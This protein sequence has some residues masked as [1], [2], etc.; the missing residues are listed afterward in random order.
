MSKSR[1]IKKSVLSPTVLIAGGAGF[2]GSHLAETLLEQKVNVVIVDNIDISGKE[3]HIENLL[4]NENFAF[5]DADINKGLPQEIESVDYVF[6]LTGVETYM[7]S[8]G[9]GLETLLANSLGTKNLLDFAQNCGA[10][11][12]LVSSTD[13]Y[14][15]LL[16]SQNLIHYFGKTEFEERRYSLIEAKRYAEALVWE[17]FKKYDL[18]ARIV[19]IPKVFGPRMPLNSTD[20]L[21]SAIKDLLE[22]HNLRLHG[23]GTEKN[24]YLYI[25]D[26]V[27]GILKAVFSGE[28]KGNIYSLVTKEPFTALEVIYLLKSMANRELNVEFKPKSG[29]I[30]QRFVE[31]DTTNLKELE[32][33][34]KIDFKSGMA[35]TLKWF[36]Y[37]TNEHSF[38]AN[39]LI[40]EN[41]KNKNKANTIIPITAIA[42]A[43]AEAPQPVEKQQHGFF[44]KKDK[45]VEMQTRD[46]PKVV[47]Q[48]QLKEVQPTKP[49]SPKATTLKK[50][51]G[52]VYK[53]FST[54]LKVLTPILFIAIALVGVPMAQTYFYATKARTSLITVEQD[55]KK[56]DFDSAQAHSNAAYLDFQKAQNSLKMS[57]WLFKISG[58]QD[59]YEAL[60]NTLNS[61]ENFSKAIY[62]GTKAASPFS[63]IWS[64]LR[65]DLENR[66]TA[67]QVSDT[68]FYLGTAKG[69][70]NLADAIAK[71]IKADD[72]PVVMQDDIK[73]Y[74]DVL[75]MA[76]QNITAIEAVTKNLDEIIGTEEP[77]KYLILFQNSNE[78]RPTGGFIGSYAV[79]EMEEGKIK[80]LKIDD[81]YNPDGQLDIKEFENPA[82]EPLKVLLQ[83]PNLH[84]RNAN[85]DPDFTKSAQE[86]SN[87][88]EQVDG[89]QFDGVIAVDLEFVRSLLEVTGPVFLTAYNEEVSAGNLYEKTQYHS[90]FNYKEGESQK[91][92]FLTVLGSKLLERTFAI[93]KEKTP[94]LVEMLRNN[95]GNRH[96]LL[97]VQNDATAGII[98]KYGWDGSLAKTDGDYL[99]VVN[100]NLGGNKADYF[101]EQKLDYQVAALTRDG[102]LRGKVTIDYTHKGKDTAWPGGEY[103]NF[104]RILTQNGTKLTGARIEVYED[105]EL[106][107]ID[108]ATTA[109]KQTTPTAPTNQPPVNTYTMDLTGLTREQ[110]Q[111]YADIT[112]NPADLLEKVVESNLG[113]Y[114]SYGFFLR[115]QPK[116]TV[117]LVVEYDLPTS[118][119]VTKDTKSYSL[120]WQKQPGTIEDTFSF[121]FDA[122]FGRNIKD[123]RV[124]GADT[125]R[126]GI[127]TNKS[128]E[129][130]VFEYRGTLERNARIHINY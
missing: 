38:K 31:P 51:H 63:D 125:P 87:L 127:G 89:S 78:L 60:Q 113:R 14:H 90:E 23:E 43:P 29:E 91:R 13:V 46:K 4:K 88:F 107:N 123:G 36:G 67:Q 73:K 44:W 65:L 106:I 8:D 83:E 12:L 3:I 15:G 32:W 120:F 76:S 58:R 66:I 25:S 85:W 47:S 109:A 57:S 61:T 116:Q 103:R 9:W 101:V 20:D 80:N 99:Y 53:F 77:K 128:K 100:A 92:A 30:Q 19:R 7:Y 28:T 110:Q 37:E 96:I 6:H 102:V 75:Q 54:T 18:D 27:T 79:L 34:A 117:K 86:I 26:A 70:L 104:V 130:D 42:T 126:T 39:K 5:F 35:N 84:I 33:D 16:S 121:K 24:Y 22:D 41:E 52:S 82:P 17:Y 45:A 122:P 10:K 81:I 119:S 112:Q 98:E 115:I 124:L 50:Q 62:F 95:L 68:N 21:N 71:D 111:V 64:V 129:N 69:S 118:L 105:G 74:R 55:M 48:P 94:E 72:L 93:P 2:I 40:E 49:D 59:S 11:F 97:S 108:A 56:L 114:T 1:I